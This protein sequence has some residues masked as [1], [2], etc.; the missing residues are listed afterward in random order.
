MIISLLMLAPYPW[1]ILLK[2]GILLDGD[3][4]PAGSIQD[5]RGPPSEF[6]ERIVCVSAYTMLGIAG[7]TLIILD[8]VQEKPGVA[9]VVKIHVSLNIKLSNK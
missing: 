1:R 6:L 7:F 5:I 2:V 4:T 9:S 8:S 3:T